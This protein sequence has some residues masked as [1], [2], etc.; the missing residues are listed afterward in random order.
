MM[1]FKIRHIAIVAAL[2]IG[3]LQ[4]IPAHAQWYSSYPRQAR[5]YSNAVALQQPYAIEVAPNTYVI[6]RPADAHDE[7]RV[8]CVQD[9]GGRARPVSGRH[10]AARATLK[11]EPKPAER[12]L[13]EELQKRLQGKHQVAVAAKIVREPP[14]VIVHRRVVEDPP[15][16]IERVVEEA[17]PTERPLYRQPRAVDIDPPLPPPPRHHEVE[18]SIKGKAA[19]A[20]ADPKRV[21][22]AEAEITILGPDR[23][24]I[25]LYRKPR[26]SDA[27]ARAQ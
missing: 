21:I 14:I 9:C 25:R 6:R 24:S 27:D 20:A 22:H 8:L 2:A 3:V 19:R 16:V 10:H 17:P 7:A 11:H 26:G 13:I 12:A 15:R 5:A 4:A 23:M 18:R 1:N